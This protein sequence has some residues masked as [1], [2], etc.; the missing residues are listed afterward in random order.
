MQ[1]PQRSWHLRRLQQLLSRISL[2][3]NCLTMSF[4]AYRMRSTILSPLPSPSRLL[5]RSRITGPYGT[6]AGVRPSTR[7]V[8][9]AKSNEGGDL[10]DKVTDIVRP[11]FVP[12]PVAKAILF[13][14][15]AGFV[16][17]LVQKVNSAPIVIQKSTLQ[18]AV[19]SPIMGSL[20]NT[21]CHS[22]LA[23]LLEIW[24]IPIGLTS[25]GIKQQCAS[26]KR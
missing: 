19:S 18:E 22:H 10:A 4:T 6:G 11:G 2:D 20:N 17:S 7:L 16:W 1:S 23:C 13:S 12:R 3:E 8:V 9:Q 21:I 5:Y 15:G 25:F 14:F 24:L 26:Y